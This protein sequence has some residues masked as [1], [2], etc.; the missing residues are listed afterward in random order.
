MIANAQVEHIKKYSQFMRKVKSLY[1]Q[2]SERI[3]QKGIDEMILVST[4]TGGVLTPEL[5]VSLSEPE[6]ATLHDVFD[7]QSSASYRVSTAEELLDEIEYVISSDGYVYQI[8][9]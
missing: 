8:S 1:P 6:E 5:L 9:K 2:Y 4:S 7:W 3:I